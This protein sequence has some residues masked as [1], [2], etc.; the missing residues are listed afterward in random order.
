LPRGFWEY[1]ILE[2]IGWY[3]KYRGRPIGYMRTPNGTPLV[4]P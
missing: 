2:T 4:A 3:A 1:R